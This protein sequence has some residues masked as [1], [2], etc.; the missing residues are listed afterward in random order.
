MTESRNAIERNQKGEIGPNLKFLFVAELFAD[1]LP[2]LEGAGFVNSLFKKAA[3]NCRFS[4]QTTG[5]CRFAENRLLQI[6]VS[7]LSQSPSVIP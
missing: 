2:T 3:A 4:Q 5:T 7:F 6:G 1:C